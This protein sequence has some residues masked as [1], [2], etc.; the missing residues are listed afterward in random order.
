MGIDLEKNLGDPF[1]AQNTRAGD[2]LR[3]VFNGIDP[4]AQLTSCYV[5][6]IG[7]SVVEIR[8]TGAFVFD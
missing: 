2:V 3:L 1:S 5:S 8:E 7:S 6:L 4:A